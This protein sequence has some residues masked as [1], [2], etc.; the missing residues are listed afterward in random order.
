MPDSAECWHAQQHETSFARIQAKW[1]AR[2]IYLNRKQIAILASYRLSESHEWPCD[3]HLCA[4]T[5]AVL[6]S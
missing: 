3:Y 2:F 5:K 4:I 1:D 6:P